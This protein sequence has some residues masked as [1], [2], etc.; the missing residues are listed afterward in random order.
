[1]NVLLDTKIIYSQKICKQIESLLNHRRSF[2]EGLP[3]FRKTQLSPRKPAS[4]RVASKLLEATLFQ[5]QL[6]TGWSSSGDQSNA[7]S[8]DIHRQN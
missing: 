2:I 5:G 4:I 1:M 7:H 3:R 6:F 8:V